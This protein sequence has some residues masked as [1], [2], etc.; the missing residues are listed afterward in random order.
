MK[1][2]TT[3]ITM[4]RLSH[5]KLQFVA[6]NQEHAGTLRMGK[7]SFFVSN[8]EVS[9]SF[10]AYSQSLLKKTMMKASKKSK[11]VLSTTGEELWWYHP[12]FPTWFGV[13]QIR[14]RLW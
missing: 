12:M 3:V 10:P 8:G 13:A 9:G 5:K 6:I 11:V 2:N 1:A 14:I 4:S 7:F